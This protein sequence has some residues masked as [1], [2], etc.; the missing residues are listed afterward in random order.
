VKDLTPILN[1]II[2]LIVSIITVF[3]IPWLKEKIE[4]EKLE[5]YKEWV[6][7]AVRAAE[8]IYK[9]TG[10]GAEKKEY[11]MSFLQ[12]KGL[13]VDMDSIENMIEAA[14]LELNKAVEAKK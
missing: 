2:T 14:V 11:V 6:T 9:G 12:S 10:R 1:A 8:Q 13:A 3:V 7:I 5:K 4:A